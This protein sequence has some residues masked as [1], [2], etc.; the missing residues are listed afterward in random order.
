MHI[1]SQQTEKAG[2]EHCEGIYEDKYH[3]YTN[4][5]ID[6]LFHTTFKSNNLFQQKRI[7]I[8]LN[9]I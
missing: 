2:L 5:Y 1:S 6:D 7:S 8:K 4:S 3:Y 9:I